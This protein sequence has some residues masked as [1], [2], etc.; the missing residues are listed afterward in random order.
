VV[1]DPISA[2]G[3]SAVVFQ[4]PVID[5][6]LSG[7]RNL[8]IHYR[9]WHIPSAVAKARIDEVVA[10]FDLGG[11][12]DRP[13]GSYSGGQRRRLEIAR[14]LVSA[15]GVLFLDEPTLGLDPRIRHELGDVLVTLRS[16][17]G[18]T[19]LVTTHYLDEAQRLCDR[20]GI[21]HKGRLVAVGTPAALTAA[22]G[23]HL[24]ELRVDCEPG[25]VLTLLRSRG[26]A[27]DDAFSVG[28]TVTIP[29]RGASPASV[30][31]E[32]TTLGL[33]TA[34]IASRQPTLEDVFLRVTGDCL[35][36]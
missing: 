35:A 21:I 6:V 32:V 8:A 28:A 13:A 9:L 10:A 36:A 31:T 18:V 12:I 30:I 17:D 2:R 20:V 7:R 4:D 1:T 23:P 3:I 25:P 22:L 15:P 26:L 16:R 24:V 33:P 34:G 27:G 14:A 5:R 11:V 29:L 19:V